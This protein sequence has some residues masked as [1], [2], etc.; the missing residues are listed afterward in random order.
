MS[1]R[2]KTDT[3][4]R[5]EVTEKVKENTE[6]MEEG[7]EKLDTVASDTETTRETLESLDFSG[8][9]EGT[10]FIEEAIEKAED[11]TVDI[12]DGQDEELDEFIDSEVKEHEQELQE[13]T[14]SSESDFE[15][16]S[17]AV[18]Q[19][20]TDQTKDELERANTEIRDDIEFIDEQQQASQESREEN[21]T[22]QQQHRNRVHGG[23][24]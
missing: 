10:D 6:K 22:L 18:D 3:P 24:R 20:A 8:T 1:K 9:A 4:T 7:V 12:F 11:L 2:R 17:D 19:I 15:K 23:G 13:R 5:G 16:V 14:D 21:E